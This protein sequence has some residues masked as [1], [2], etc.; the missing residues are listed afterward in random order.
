MWR[1]LLFMGESAL[2]MTDERKLAY[3]AP[4]MK[5]DS[6]TSAVGAAECSPKW[7]SAVRGYK[8]KKSKSPRSGRQIPNPESIATKLSYRLR[9]ADAA[10]N[11]DGG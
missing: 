7:A 3:S 2:I 4:A 9:T 10:S 1:R 6:L 8:P 5:G 11:P